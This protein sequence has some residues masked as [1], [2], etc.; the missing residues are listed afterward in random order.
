MQSNLCAYTEL[1]RAVCWDVGSGG[2]SGDAVVLRNSYRQQL[3]I[4]LE[5]LNGAQAGS[6]SSQLLAECTDTEQT[7]SVG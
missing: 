1:V 4:Q 6:A 3:Q 5:L 2:G 7:P